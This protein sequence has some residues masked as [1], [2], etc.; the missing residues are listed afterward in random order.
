[1]DSLFLNLFQYFQIGLK[2]CKIYI[3]KTSYWRD[4]VIRSLWKRF[5]GSNPTKRIFDGIFYIVFFFEKFPIYFLIIKRTNLINIKLEVLVVN[6]KATSLLEDGKVSFVLLAQHIKIVTL[7]QLCLDFNRLPIHMGPTCAHDVIPGTALTTL[8]QPCLT[9]ADRLQIMMNDIEILE[10]WECR[11]FGQ[12]AGNEELEFLGCLEQTIASIDAQFLAHTFNHSVDF[13]F[14][15]ACVIDHIKVWVTD[16]SRS[17]F[18]VQ[19][20]GQSN[21]LSASRMILG[22]VEILSAIGGWNHVNY[23]IVPI[24]TQLYIIPLVV[25]LHLF[26]FLWGQ[27]SGSVH[28]TSI[29]NDQTVSCLGHWFGQL[30]ICVFNLDHSSYKIFL[31]LVGFVW[32]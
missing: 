15:V 3:S 12:W 31:K 5:R 28:H 32:R 19:F 13:W 7:C 10:R 8:P 21:A 29:A 24:V 30:K 20:T 1:M 25:P 14:K 18:V 16:P 2:R 9:T 11:D 26:P 17:A 4:I 23:L 22:G 27:I 6:Q